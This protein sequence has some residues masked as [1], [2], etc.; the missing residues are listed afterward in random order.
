MILER[1][2]N[3]INIKAFYNAAEKSVVDATDTECEWLRH[4]MFPETLD[5]SQLLH[6]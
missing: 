4:T 3:Q 1:N 2:Q 6:F 5:I